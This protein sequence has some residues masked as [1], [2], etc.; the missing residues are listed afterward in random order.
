MPVM[1][2]AGRYDEA[3]PQTVE[4]FHSMIPRSRV[5]IMENSGHM[6]PLEEYERYAQVLRAFLNEVDSTLTSLSKSPADRARA[7]PP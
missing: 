3:R 2:I 1:L 7:S 4:K 5:A 6:A